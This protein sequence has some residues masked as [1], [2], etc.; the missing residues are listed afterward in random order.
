MIPFKKITFNSDTLYIYPYYFD[1][2]IL[3]I[4]RSNMIKYKR[5]KNISNNKRNINY[6]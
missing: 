4:I 2:S 6:R 3:Y 5:L 1:I